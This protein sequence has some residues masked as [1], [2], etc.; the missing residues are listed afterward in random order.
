MFAF[1][2]VKMLTK[3]A[4]PAGV[5]VAVSVG[6][7]WYAQL[8]LDKLAERSATIVDRDAG[9]QAAALEMALALDDAAI[10]EKSVLLDTDGADKLRDMEHYGKD[11][12]AALNSTK[13]LHDLADTDQRRATVEKLQQAIKDFSDV[14]KQV[15][16]LSIADDFAHSTEL[17]AGDGKKKRLALMAM[18]E[19]LTA[20]IAQDMDQTKASA[21]ALRVRITA[22]LMAVAVLGLLAAIGQL[23]WIAVVQVSRPV[24]SMAALMERLASGDLAVEVAG[25]DRRDEI[26]VLARSLHVFKENAVAAKR[27]ATEQQEEQSA[28][29]TR[30]R[31]RGELRQRFE[32]RMDELI[33]ALSTAAQQLEDTARKMTSTATD[34]DKQSVVVASASEQAASNVQAVAG[35][36]EELAASIREIGDRVDQS[37]AIAGKAVEEAARTDATVRTLA[38]N[39]SKI[40]EVVQLIQDIASQTNLLALNATIEAARAGDAGKGFAVV[41]SEVKSLANQTAKATEDIA[42]QITQIQGATRDAVEAIQRISTTIAEMNAIAT[43]VAAAVEQ[44]SAATGEIARNVQQAAQGTEEVSRHIELVQKTAT[45]TGAT[46]GHVL[47]AAGGVSQRAQQLS[48][49]IGEFL[50]KVN[51]A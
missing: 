29:E 21:A 35:A 14:G 49:E 20:T 22:A 6:I 51:A 23:I 10:E 45:D 34:T 37:S 11:I 26:G 5:M 32:K 24:A 19:G 15:I 44:Q 39:A 36:T 18:V 28:K 17:S 30:A 50:N 4:I 38:T 12:V 1:K 47:E 42:A 25:T 41:A 48:S 3:I 2:N 31:R 9:R 27:V 43:S 46:A 33:N 16:T 13:K 7:V 8:G 40:G